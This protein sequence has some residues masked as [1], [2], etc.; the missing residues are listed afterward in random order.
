MYWVTL[1]GIQI[2]PSTFKNLFTRKFKINI[3][4]SHHHVSIGQ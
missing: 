4:T 3:C 1:N 2:F